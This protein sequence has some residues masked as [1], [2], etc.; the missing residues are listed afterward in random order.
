MRTAVKCLSVLV[1]GFFV[2]AVGTTYADI[3][4][5]NFQEGYVDLTANTNNQIVTDT[6]TGLATT[7]TIGG[8][9]DSQLTWT[10]GAGDVT[11]GVNKN[12]DGKCSYSSPAG[13]DGLFQLD[14]GQGGDLNADL[15]AETQFALLFDVADYSGPINITVTTTGSGAST[16]MGYTPSGLQSSDPDQWVYIPFSTFTGT[17]SF[18][19]VDQISISIDGP[20]E[21]DYTLKEISTSTIPEPGTVA[22]FSLIGAVLWRFRRRRA[23]A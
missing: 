5:D 14:Y 15:S 8:R 13:V 23:T 22:M 7:N 20:S 12:S 1:V 3:M 19:D 17:A 21:A 6:D 2:M 16:G 11:L 9:R 18:A 4:I 10:S